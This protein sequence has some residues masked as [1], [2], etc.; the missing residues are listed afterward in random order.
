MAVSQEKVSILQGKNL[1]T[2]NEFQYIVQY[3][4]SWGWKLKDL[5]KILRI[6]LRLSHREEISKDMSRLHQEMWLRL[7]QWLTGNTQIDSVIVN[8]GDE[9]YSEWSSSTSVRFCGEC[10]FFS[11]EQK[12]CRKYELQLHLETVGCNQFVEPDMIKW[13]DLV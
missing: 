10:V 4:R 1:P 11:I 7:Q 2:Q 13:M 6:V 12:I 8:P 5:Y 3:I 9:H